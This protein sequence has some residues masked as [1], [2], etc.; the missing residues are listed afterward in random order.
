MALTTI[1]SYHVRDYTGDRKSIPYFVPAGGTI[2]GAQGLADVTA[3][4]LDAAIDAKIESISVTFQLDL[5]GG[6]KSAAAV[7]NTV[8]EG[9]DISFS[10][11]DTI[12]R[13]TTYVP[14]MKNT[15]FT[16]N[17]LNNSGASGAVITDLNQFTDKDGN[18]LD[19]YLEGKRAFRK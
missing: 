18:A 5:P 1:I 3:P 17:T 13:Y 4:L 14:S 16:G 6:M 8:H 19:A 7:G 10:A 11:D 9:A 2:S 12:Y 15:Q